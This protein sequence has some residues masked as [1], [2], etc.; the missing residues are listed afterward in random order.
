MVWVKAG[1]GV[2]RRLE[3]LGPNLYLTQVL[4]LEWVIVGGKTNVFIFEACL[5]VALGRSNVWNF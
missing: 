4:Q 2:M 1:M 5:F 3:L